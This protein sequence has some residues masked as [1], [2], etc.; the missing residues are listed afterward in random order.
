MIH[1]K[2]A[3]YYA[4][5]VD[6][7]GKILS[8]K[9][10]GNQIFAE[11]SVRGMK[12]ESLLKLLSGKGNRGLTIHVCPKDC[13][14]VLSDETLVHGKSFVGVQGDESPW[15][16]NLVEVIPDVP[17]ED[18]LKKLREEQERLEE[19]RRGER[20]SPKR[21]KKKDKKSK[22][23]NRAKSDEG[24]EAKPKKSKKKKA[25]DSTSEE[26]EVGQKSLREVYGQT[27][28]DPD[29]KR[30]NRL[31]KK[32]K[33]VGKKKKKKKS[34]S[35]EEEESDS[36]GTTST[37]SVDGG[38]GLFDGEQKL[39]SIW[40]RYPGAL[41]NSAS[42]EDRQHLVAASGVVWAVD[43]TKVSPVFTLYSRQCLMPLMNPPMAQETITI[44]QCLDY[45]LQGHIAAGCDILAQRLKA[46][47]SS[48]REDTGRCQGSLNL[49][50]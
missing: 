48:A 14:N 46:L 43:K 29:P 8:A 47:E 44:S 27:G 32:A 2:K 24:E 6:I 22:K 38:A 19:L 41:A 28:L 45:L 9:V 39:Q 50:S 25:E 15:M 3:Q 11:M 31:A 40:K 35:G 1:L 26:L 17:V 37:S 42:N 49:S 33:R 5:E 4:S 20:K 30:R 36:S 23:K 13:G 34:A 7:V 12:D 21:E 18:E 16:S 10:E